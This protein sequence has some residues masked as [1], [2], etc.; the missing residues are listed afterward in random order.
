MNQ[1]ILK[2]FNL[3]NKIIDPKDNFGYRYEDIVDL[4]RS[5]YLS[6]NIQQSLIYKDI[7]NIIFG[8]LK[9]FQRKEI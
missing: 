1:F 3:Q 2:F 8:G 7:P 5:N 4:Y 9:F 6:R